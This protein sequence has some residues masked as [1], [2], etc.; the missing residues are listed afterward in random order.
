MNHLFVIT[1]LL[2]IPI[3][4]FT[5]TTSNATPSDPNGADPS[6]IAETGCRIFNSC[7]SSKLLLRRRRDNSGGQGIRAPRQ[8]GASAITCPDTYGCYSLT[9]NG[10]LFCL[11]L[12]SFDYITGDGVCGNAFSGSQYVCG[13]TT[14][15]YS[16]SGDGT[17]SSGMG[18]GSGGGGD[19]YGNN[20]GNGN[21]QGSGSGNGN[22]NGNGGG[23]SGSGSG[24]GSPKPNGAGRIAIIHHGYGFSAGFMALSIGILVMLFQLV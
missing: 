24:S 5:C 18:S 7:T 6:Q 13:S 10:G 22:R 19:G 4:G 12:N 11:D 16:G 3:R 14:G 20:G 9:S 2:V 17:G 8:V 15:S 23:G 1:T 21:D